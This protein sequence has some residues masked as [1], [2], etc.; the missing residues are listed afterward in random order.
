MG[1]RAGFRGLGFRVWGAPPVT[2]CGCFFGNLMSFVWG[3]E[4]QTN[5]KPYMNPTSPP[6]R[7]IGSYPKMTP[8]EN[9]KQELH[10]QAGSRWSLGGRGPRG[11]AVYDFTSLNSLSSMF[12][13]YQFFP[14]HCK[15]LRRGPQQQQRKYMHSRTYEPL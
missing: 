4:T 10:C 7:V 5:P 11:F 15:G 6:C 14:A 13:F 3:S 8:P 12:C 9:C 1:F 2:V